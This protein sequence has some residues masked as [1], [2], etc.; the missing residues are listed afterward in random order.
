[1][2]RT[3]NAPFSVR[4]MLP[5]RS[6]TEIA[7]VLYEM[8]CMAQGRPAASS[9]LTEVGVKSA[10]NTPTFCPW[11]AQ[12]PV[13]EGW[14]SKVRVEILKNTPT[15][16]PGLRDFVMGAQ[17]A[18]RT[19]MARD[20]HPDLRTNRLTWTI[21]KGQPHS[22]EASSRTPSSMRDLSRKEKLSRIVLRWLP[23]G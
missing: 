20:G 6:R 8:L 2:P 15:C 7:L 9:V 1:M 13:R 23:S 22:S 12:N 3:E 17:P 19:R 10:V 14:N 5:G 18:R 11:R 4:E 21:A 16:T